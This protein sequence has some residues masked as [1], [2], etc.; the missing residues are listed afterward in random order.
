MGHTKGC[1]WQK[2][3]LHLGL[4]RC[5]NAAGLAIA[6]DHRCVADEALEVSRA[7]ESRAT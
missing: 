2:W 6:S 1:G 4:G 5:G 3:G 7:A